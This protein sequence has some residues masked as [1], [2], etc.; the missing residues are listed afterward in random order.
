MTKKFILWL[1]I[2][3]ICFT[4][5]VL[6]AGATEKE[7][8]SL[9]SVDGQVEAVLELP[10]APAEDITA[11]Q[12][13][14][15]ITNGGGAGG[16][17]SF[18]F[19]PGLPQNG[20]QE[21]RYQEDTG[22]L[23][24]YISGNENLYQSQNISLGKV[25]VDSGVETSVRVIKNSFKTVNRAH[26]MYEG[27]VN[28]G[29]GGQT[30][31][32]GSD[33]KPDDSLFPDGITGSPGSGTGVP[34]QESSGGADKDLSADSSPN[35][36]DSSSGKLSGGIKN[37]MDTL[38]TGTAEDGISRPGGSSSGFGDNDTKKEDT[39]ES[40]ESFWSEGAEFWEE[41]TGAVDMDVW[42]KVFLGLFAGSASIAAVIGI[43]LIAQK[44]RKR[45]RR[46][47]QHRSG[48]HSRGQIHRTSSRSQNRKPPRKPQSRRTSQKSSKKRP[49]EKAQGRRPAGKNQTQKSSD[50]R[51]ARG[52]VQKM[53]AHQEQPVWKGKEPYVRKRRKIG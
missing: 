28:T 23:S 35:A 4:A 33:S 19:D 26:G 30:V 46:K 1:G 44:A 52:R 9:N 45:R 49:S 37:V 2:S 20:V 17:V 10:D 12:L 8:V 51:R 50:T 42:T 38:W 14:F 31:N 3:C 36:S 7:T 43:S 34:D 53:P 16:N 32:N 29:D 11:L 6:S 48:G 40:G 39:G 47:I 41:K 25:V 21:Y 22:I 13:S 24:I 15:Q 27:E 18:A 5:F